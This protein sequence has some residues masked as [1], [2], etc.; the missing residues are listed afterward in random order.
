M[1]AW[2]LFAKYIVVGVNFKGETMKKPKYKC[3]KK[4]TCTQCNKNSITH[5]VCNQ[6]V[7]VDCYHEFVEFQDSLTYD[8]MT[9]PAYFEGER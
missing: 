5:I 7:C 1:M 2:K 3:K 6:R 4:Y 9:D 8:K